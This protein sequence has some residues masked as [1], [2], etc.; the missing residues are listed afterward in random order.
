[1][2]VFEDVFHCLVDGHFF[3]ACDFQG[4]DFY[5]VLDEPEI[6]FFFE[7]DVFLRL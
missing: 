4:F 3:D 6:I 1:M 2:L 5:G 7:L